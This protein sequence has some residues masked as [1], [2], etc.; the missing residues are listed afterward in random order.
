MISAV[1]SWEQE[2]RRRGR[3]AGRSAH[4]AADEGNRG[5]GGRSALWGPDMSVL[6]AVGSDRARNY[7]HNY[8]PITI[9]R[10]P[11][12]PTGGR[13]PQPPGPGRPVRT[14][15][16]WCGY[17]RTRILRS[18]CQLPVNFLRKA[19]VLARKGPVAGRS[20]PV[21]APAKPADRHRARAA[22]RPPDEGSR[23]SDTER[24]LGGRRPAPWLTPP[25]PGRLA[26][27]DARDGRSKD[28]RN[29][30]GVSRPSQHAG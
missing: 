3:A 26:G 16:F 8:R 21:P 10:R 24:P 6:G 12:A 14:P 5:P 9:D 4:P 11:G 17:I 29:R 13:S 27:L 20:A 28:S 25:C 23:G 15:V 30:L 18:R 1:T 2:P 7:R 22:P 19:L